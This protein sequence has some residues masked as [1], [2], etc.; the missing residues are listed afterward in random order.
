MK[1][2]PVGICTGTRALGSN[3]GKSRGWTTA[4]SAPRFQHS[5]TRICPSAKSMKPILIISG[6]FGVREVYDTDDTLPEF[7]TDET[8]NL[9]D[10]QDMEIRGEWLGLP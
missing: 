5:S 4:E 2:K 10:R 3:A 7:N 8:E 1:K 9:P 6:D